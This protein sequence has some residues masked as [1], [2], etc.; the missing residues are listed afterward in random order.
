MKDVIGSQ[1]IEF[2]CPHCG[3]KLSHTV[4][5]LTTQAQITCSLCSQRFSLD[6][7]DAKRKIAEVE[8]ALAN[9]GKSLGRLGK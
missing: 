3:G 7:T 1:R 2:P 6:N 4:R 8:K 5:K 9:F